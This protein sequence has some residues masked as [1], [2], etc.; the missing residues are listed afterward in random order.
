MLMQFPQIIINGGKYETLILLV[1]CFPFSNGS[2]SRWSHLITIEEEYIQ[3]IGDLFRA[4]D[5]LEVLE[6]VLEVRP[7]EP[8]DI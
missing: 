8:I 6:P 3:D 7:S 4:Q 1:V 2:L 5:N